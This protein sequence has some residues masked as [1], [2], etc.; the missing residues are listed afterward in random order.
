MNIVDK[1]KKYAIACHSETNHFY[2]E[3]PYEYHLQMVVDVAE[4]FKFLIPEDKQ[5][6]V[7]AACWVHDVIE[8]CRQSYNDVAK[9]TSQDVADL[10][11]AVTTEKGKSRKERANEKYYNGIKET[12]FATFIKVCDRIA[13]I[14]HSKSMQS[15]MFQVYSKENEGFKTKLWDTK[16]LQLF[17]Y[18]DKLFVENN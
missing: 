2:D 6:N 10:A 4:K 13:N 3:H 5:D 7:V 9:A 12:P 17:D 11:Y 15:R 18:M 8:D 16:Y 14:K 1:A